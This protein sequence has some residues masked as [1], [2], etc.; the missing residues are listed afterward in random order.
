MP[1][2]SKEREIKPPER[3]TKPNFDGLYCCISQIHLNNSDYWYWR[4]QAK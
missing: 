1:P 3:E 4:K 2:E